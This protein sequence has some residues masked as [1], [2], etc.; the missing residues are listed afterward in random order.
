MHCISYYID[1]LVQE[2]CNPIANA[3]ELH[4]SCTN[5]SVWTIFHLRL[6]MCKHM[7]AVLFTSMHCG[8]PPLYNM[9]CI[10]VGHW[11]WWMV[12]FQ[13]RK[14]L[15]T[16]FLGLEPIWQRNHNPKFV[17]ITIALSWT[18]MIKSGHNFAHGTTAELLWHVQNCGL[19]ES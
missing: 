15:Y 18:I 3:L 5:P 1:G 9:H 10:I 19:I 14:K 2:R 6:C 8:L 16:A 7:Q 12:R 17:K 4:L 13:C 11:S